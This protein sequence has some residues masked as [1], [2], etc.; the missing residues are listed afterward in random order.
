MPMNAESRMG[1]GVAWVAGASAATLLSVLFVDR[2][3][4]TWS[5]DSLHAA[6]VFRDLTHIIDPIP[7]LAVV[8]FLAL[9]T[10]LLFGWRPGPLSRTLLYACAAVLVAIAV[11]DQLKFAFGRLWPETWV[12][13]NPSWIKDGAYG[14]APFHGKAGWTSFPSGHMTVITA[15]M[16]VVWQRH[17]AWR[18]FAAIPVALVAVGLYGADFH[19]VGDMIAGT[20]LGSVCAVLVVALVPDRVSTS[21]EEIQAEATQGLV[22]R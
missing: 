20:L 9:G 4:A 8:G 19:F 21:R 3:A 18:A 11:K 16:A 13:N 14:F 17:R 6:L 22:P 2:G 5:H 7:P 15:P 1:S 10:S 12:D